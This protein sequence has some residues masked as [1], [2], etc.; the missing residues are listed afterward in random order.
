MEVQCHQP[1]LSL[2]QFSRIERR[3]SS[4]WSS[5]LAASFTTICPTAKCSPRKKREESFDK[6]RPRFTTVTSTKSA[7]VTW[8]SRTFCWTRMETPKWV[9]L[10][11]RWAV[12]WIV[13]LSRLQISV[14]RTF[15]MSRGCWPRFVARR[16]MLRLKLW[17][18]HHIKDPRWTAGRL[19]CCCTVSWETLN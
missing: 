18:E 17:K 5:Q 11:G 2:S 8:S 9:G 7:I 12:N 15:L 3:W 16:F 4:S 19:A 1:R 6:C 14:C 13:R 10:W